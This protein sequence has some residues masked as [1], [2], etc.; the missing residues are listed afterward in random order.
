MDKHHIIKLPVFNSLLIILLSL[1]FNVF[2]E[3]AF[4]DALTGGKVDFGVRVR[5]EHVG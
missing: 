2:A 5:Y 1:S 3:L 4:M